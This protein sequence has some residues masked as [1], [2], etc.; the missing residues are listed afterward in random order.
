MR[1]I[2]NRYV[3]GTSKAAVIGLSKAVAADFI[4][5]GIRC[6]AVAPGPVKTPMLPPTHILNDLA[7]NLSALGRIAEIDDLVGVYHFL[8]SDQSRYITGQ[9][10]VV[11]GGRLAG[12]RN[13]VLGR[14]A[15]R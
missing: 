4:K 6:N 12:F 3:Y 8:V 14:L 1:G 11:D 7:K 9:T 10:I 2:P 13:E 15:G 5:R